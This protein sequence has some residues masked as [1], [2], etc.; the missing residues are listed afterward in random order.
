WSITASALPAGTQVITATATSGAGTSAASDALSLTLDL[1]APT[2]TL[3]SPSSALTRGGPVTFS[4]TYADAA[5]NAA[6][7]TAANITLNKTGT[8]DGTIAVSGSGT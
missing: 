2:V 6:T 8:A 3:G 4:V 1:T 7:L 5:F